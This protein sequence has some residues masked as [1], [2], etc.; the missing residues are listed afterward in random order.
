M[1]ASATPV[2]LFDEL[3]STRRVQ[4]NS[5]CINIGYVINQTTVVVGEGTEMAVRNTARQ[6]MIR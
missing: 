5:N 4:T 1:F 3:I 6:Y 2:G